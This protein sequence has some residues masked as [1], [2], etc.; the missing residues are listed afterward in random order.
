MDNK[1]TSIYYLSK[2]VEDISFI[3]RKTNGITIEQFSSDEVLN[4]AINF[5][6]I[7]ISE[8]VK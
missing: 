4:C 2:I 8:T 6:F 1:K 3:I 7:Q 5:K